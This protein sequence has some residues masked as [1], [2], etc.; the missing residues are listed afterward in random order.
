M[1][2]GQDDYEMK[3]KKKLGDMPGGEADTR[4]I[5]GRRLTQQEGGF[6]PTPGELTQR[7]G[8]LTL[9]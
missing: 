7:A 8:R 4:M 5:P 6:L 2:E 9:V 1:P 3:N